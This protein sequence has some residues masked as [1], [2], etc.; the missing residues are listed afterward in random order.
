MRMQDKVAIITGG[1]SGIGR[2]ICLK[3]A[4]EGAR[5]AVWDIDLQG[6][7]ATASD[8]EKAGGKA[9]ASRVDVSKAQDIDTATEEAIAQLG[10]IDILVNNAGMSQIS[11]VAK[12]SEEDW[13]RIH[14][15]NLKGAFLCCKAI[16]GHMKER[17]YG[18]IVNI[19]SILA[20][21]GSAFYAHYSSTKAG[22]VGLT[23]GLAMELGPHGINVNAVGPGV[24]DTPMLEQDTT[25]ELRERVQKSIPL[26]R[27]GEPH[28]MAN[29]V[30]F[31]ASDEAAYITGQSLFVCGGLSASAG[32]A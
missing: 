14:E 12:L 23:K 5:V 4:E 10:G 3:L 18:K 20:Q 24:I 15:V 25:P 27:I 26:R 8:I 29:A 6:A 32:L 2:S 19:T 16:S 31:L 21:G 17:G 13:D 11:T 9:V 30:L 7:Q 22:L 28:D 1:A